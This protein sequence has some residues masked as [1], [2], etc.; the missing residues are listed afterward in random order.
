MKIT[1]IWPLSIDSE[2][3][4]SPTPKH[5]TTASQTGAFNLLIWKTWK[6]LQSDLSHLQQFL[7]PLKEIFISF[8]KLWQGSTAIMG[9]SLV[10]PFVHPVTGGRTTY[11]EEATL[12]NT[13][14][15]NTIKKKGIK[16]QILTSWKNCWELEKQLR[17]VSF[18]LYPIRKEVVIFSSGCAHRQQPRHLL[19][20]MRYSDMFK[21]LKSFTTWKFHK[22]HWLENCCKRDKMKNVWDW[23]GTAVHF[24][25]GKR[26]LEDTE[27]G[28][29]SWGF[30]FR[31]CVYKW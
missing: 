20:R 24:E 31:H 13:T 15:L 16:S 21:T 14:L 22:S 6:I 3:F 27:H 25:W 1:P 18:W 29:R 9:L 17:T 10:I 30:F 19:T 23:N 5:L 26:D 2:R 11:Y 4:I 7:H 28:K 12:L 8:Q